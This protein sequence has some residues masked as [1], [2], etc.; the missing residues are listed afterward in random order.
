MNILFINYEYPPIGAGAA[1]ATKN[2]A[3]SFVKLGHKAVV[4]TSS[5]KEYRGEMN[6]NG[7]HVIRVPS[8]RKKKSESNIFEMI[9]F[10]LSGFMNLN[11][12]I[13]KYNIDYS[14]VFFS[15]PCGPLGLFGWL[16]RKIPYIISLRGGDVPG[17]E[18]GIEFIQKVIAPLRRVILRKSI[19]IIA[20]SQ[21]LADLSVK[22]DPYEV[23]VIPNGVDVDFFYPDDSKKD[24]NVF[25]FLFVGRFQKQKN[26]FLLLD[27]IS[28]IETNFELHMVGDGPLKE[29]LVVLSKEL[30]IYNRIIWYGW[31]DKE[32]LREIYQAADC[33]INPSLYEGMPNVLLEAMACG[34]PAI[35]SNVEGNNEV[36]IIEKTGFLFDLDEPERFLDLL[37]YVTIEQSHLKKMGETARINAV[38]KYSWIKTT[39]DYVKILNNMKRLY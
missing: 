4:I 33:L 18:P 36:I 10:V 32:E 2:I 31:V 12:I 15:I 21:G 7:I 30:N 5:Y 29:D 1:N 34:L 28:K 3:K 19:S 13:D 16:S 24:Q 38:E 35:A 27:K 11:K 22:H 6:E 39:S 37:K 23:D 25:R 14:I 17:T 26:L 8:I 9:S 20:N